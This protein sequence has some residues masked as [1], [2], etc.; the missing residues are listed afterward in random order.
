MATTDSNGLVLIDGSDSIQPLHPVL[1]SIT[2]SVSNAFNEQTRIYPATSL[3]ART[4]LY[5]KHGASLSKPLFVWYTP[6]PTGRNLMYSV[7]GNTTND[8]KYYSSDA[9]ATQSRIW[10]VANVT[11]RTTIFNAVGPGTTSNPV[12][13]WRADAPAGRQLEYNVTNSNVTDN[14]HYVKTSEDDTGWVQCPTISPFQPQGSSS[15]R[16]RRTG[17]WVSIEWGIAPTGVT[18]NSVQNVATV[19]VGFR[20]PSGVYLGAWT[21]VAAARNAGFVVE[22]PGNIQLRTAPTVGGYFLIPSGSGWYLD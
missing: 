10:K 13:V 17:N 16:V 20:P 18:A 4:T 15:F 8:W 3:T 19:P 6:A 11:G 5:N 7:G 22:A 9:D 14:W 2:T 12:I 21:N 1:N